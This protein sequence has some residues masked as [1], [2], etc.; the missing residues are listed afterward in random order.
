MSAARKFPPE[1]RVWGLTGGIA[2]GKSSVAKLFAAQG[3]AVI[4]ADKLSRELT[5]PGG[6]AH[7]A[8]VKRFGTDD[9]RKIRD[10][11]FSDPA[12]RL[13]LEAILHP[14]IR[15]ESAKAVAAAVKA[16]HKDILYEA[17]L[18]VET[19]RYRDFDGLLVVEAP[20]EVRIDRLMARDGVEREQAEAMIRAQASDEQ[21]RLA[22]TVILSNDGDEDRL[23]HSVAEA[24]GRIFPR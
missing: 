24:M 19:E 22:A 20:R 4:D 16:G 5:L 15:E 13:D 1:A 14:L 3:V 9:R 18:L 8:V 17:A 10:A 11:V 23:A 21:R 2:A 7:A 6:R 12:A